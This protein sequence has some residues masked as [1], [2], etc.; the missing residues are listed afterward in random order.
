LIQNISRHTSRLSTVQGNAQI[1]VNSEGGNFQGALEVNAHLPD[2]LFAKIEGP[3]GVD[4]ALIQLYSDN[5]LFY[6]PFMNMAFSGSV[7]DSA[8][9]FLPFKPGTRDLLLYTLGLLKIPPERVNDIISFYSRDGQYVFHFQ[10]GERVWIHPKG[11]VITR[12]EKTDEEGKVAWIWEGKQFK[13]T[14]GV[15]LPQMIRITTE[16]PKQKVVV[17]YTKRRANRNLKAGWSQL[18]LPEGVKPVEN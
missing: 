2:S 10:D 4:M 8:S 18:K 12:W 17:F 14:G 7:N 13:K 9:A 16:N 11:P 1:T 15:R 5:L 6:S 3:F